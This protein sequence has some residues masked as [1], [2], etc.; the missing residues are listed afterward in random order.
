MVVPIVAI[1]VLRVNRDH[2]VPDSSNSSGSSSSGDIHLC[3]ICI[4]HVEVIPFPAIILFSGLI[5]LS[6]V[7]LADSLFLQIGSVDSFGVIIGNTRCFR[8]TGY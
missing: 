7:D 2:T 1:F 6:V 4:G 5:P 3:G 8:S